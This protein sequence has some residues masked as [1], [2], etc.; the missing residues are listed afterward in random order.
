M[1]KTQWLAAAP[2]HQTCGQLMSVG[3]GTYRVTEAKQRGLRVT[4]SRVTPGSQSRTSDHKASSVKLVV[5]P[6]KTTRVAFLNKAAHKQPKPPH[7]SAGTGYVEVCKYPGDRWVHGSVTVSVTSGSTTLSQIVPVGQCTGALPVPAGIATVSETAPY[8]TYLYD[9]ITNPASALVSKDLSTNSA[10]VKVKASADG[11]DETLVKLINRTATGQFKVCKTLSSNSGDVITSGNNT[12]YFDA[13]FRLA[14]SSDWYSL[15]QIRVIVPTLEQAACVLFWKPLPLGTEVRVT[16]EKATA[17]TITGVS[18]MPQSQDLGSS[19]DTADFTIGPKQDG[20]TTASF[21]NMADGTL[22][23]CKTL[24]HYE[25]LPF[26]FSVNGGSPITVKAG[27]CSPPI[28]VPAGTATV[29]ELPKPNFALVG[30]TAT[31]PDGNSRLVSGTNPITINVPF[32]GVGNE[33]LVTATNRVTTAQ[34]KVCKVLDPGVPVGKS[35]DF[36]TEYTVWGKSFR[37]ETTLQPTD[38][39]PAGE[40]CGYLSYPFPVVLPDG[41]GVD[42]TVTEGPSPFGLDQND[43]PIVEPTQ[44]TY[45]GNGTASAP[46]VWQ[47]GDTGA[48]DGTY[49]ISAELGQGVNVI[50]F[51]NSLVLDP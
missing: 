14:D 24:P 31:G 33:T 49:G 1:H 43:N 6:G 3:R 37:D 20:I 44:I 23:I 47:P 39:G 19:G 42:V 7:G 50:T 18:V 8:P 51:T 36:Y 27:A 29:E 21:T 25:G 11:S 13:S 48:K 34:L 2:G 12:F 32:G 28:S 38:V 46:S 45:E 9:V 15:G 16:E 41:S 22:E 5:A 4:H 35:Y 17:I 26:Q 30:F 40:V 10:K